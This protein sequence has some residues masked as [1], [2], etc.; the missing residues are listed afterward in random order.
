MEITLEER[1]YRKYGHRLTVEQVAEELSLEAQTVY[2]KIYR[3]SLPVPTYKEGRR[4]WCS[5]KVLAA[6]LEGRA[7]EG[8]QA[9]GLCSA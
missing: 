8:I 2:N 1:L 5:T 3:D 6:Y 7:S 9:L 4:R